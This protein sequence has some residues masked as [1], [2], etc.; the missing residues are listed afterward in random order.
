M[1]LGFAQT[2]QLSQEMRQQMRISPQMRQAFE[3]LEL[4]LQ[5]LRAKI[6]EELEKNPVV[7]EVRNPKT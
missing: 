4:P 5:D 7:E 6:R 1:P 3:V 2:T